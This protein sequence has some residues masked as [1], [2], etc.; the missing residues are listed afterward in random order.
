MGRLGNNL[1]QVGNTLALAEQLK[2]RVQLPQQDTWGQMPDVDFREQVT[3]VGAQDDEGECVV[4]SRFYY[5]KDWAEKLAGAGGAAEAPMPPPP[6]RSRLMLRTYLWPLLEAALPELKGAVGPGAV[7]PAAVNRTTLVIHVR[8]GDIFA[9]TNFTNPCTPQP[10]LSFYTHVIRRWGYRDVLVVTERPD[11]NFAREVELKEGGWDIKEAPVRGN[12]T[13][14]ALVKWAQEGDEGEGVTVRMQAGT[15]GQDAA[16]LLGARHLMLSFGTFSEEFALLSDLAVRVFSPWRHVTAGINGGAENVAFAFDGFL[17]P[18]DW[19]HTP[20]QRA[21][22]LTHQE[23]EVRRL[24]PRAAG[25]AA[26]VT[27]VLWQEQECHQRLR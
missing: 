1:I 16:A 25:E 14:E 24:P 19:K 15:I 2:A 8:S 17:Q 18:G 5:R 13:A 23:S 10:P 3:G 21:A 6:A 7:A 4:E 11:E 27:D 9:Y 20:E 22:M 26:T 12:P